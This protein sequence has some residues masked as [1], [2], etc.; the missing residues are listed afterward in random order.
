MATKRPPEFYLPLW[1]QAE[2]EKFGIE[3]TTE[4]DDVMIL[5]NSLYDCR[6]ANP[7]RFGAMMISQPPPAG[8]IFIHHK[9]VELPE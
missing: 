5:I 3:I 1:E 8:T 9:S 6:R 2:K 4:P 7:G